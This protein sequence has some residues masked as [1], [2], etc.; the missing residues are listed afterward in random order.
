[1]ELSGTALPRTCRSWGIYN[2]V[3][4]Q[5]AAISHI[6]HIHWFEQAP[7]L[8]FFFIK[9]PYLS[10]DVKL[11]THLRLVPRSMHGCMPPLFQYAFMA[12]CSV[13]HMERNLSCIILYTY[14]ES[15]NT[16]RFTWRIPA[17]HHHHHLYNHNYH[18]LCRIGL[19]V[20]RWCPHLLLGCPVSFRRSGLYPNVY[21]DTLIAFI[22]YMRCSQL[23]WQSLFSA[24]MF[25]KLFE[26]PVEE[27]H[28]KISGIIE[29]NEDLW[30]GPWK[31]YTSP[32]NNC[33]TAA[34]AAA[35]V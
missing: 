1:V 6:L 13:K 11:T 23:L 34:A 3:D 2:H 4:L 8:V 32:R 21:V 20:C 30:G 17:F 18:V 27:Y 15:S 29:K 14:W 25:E 10:R 16:T 5:V 35:A 33:E 31:A 26:C 7:L 28:S 24:I 9:K 19:T 22:L 12:W